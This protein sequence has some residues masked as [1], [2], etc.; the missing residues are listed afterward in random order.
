MEL[1]EFRTPKFAPYFELKSLAGELVSIDDYDKPLLLINFWATWCGPCVGELPLFEK[2]SEEFAARGLAVINVAVFDREQTVAS[3]LLRRGLDLDVL[4]DPEGSLLGEFG[5]TGVPAVV[6][7][8]QND[9]MV[10]FP[11]PHSGIRTLTV[12][13]PRNWLS[14]KFL[15]FI[16]RY[17]Q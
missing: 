16:D 11:D 9:A 8:D 3:L 10:A 7:I 17:L 15:E 5:F 14:P 2:L 4:L 13:G 12:E 1:P 6:L